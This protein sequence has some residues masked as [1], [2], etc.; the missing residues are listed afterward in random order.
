MKV[1]IGIKIKIKSKGI[2]LT[3]ISCPFLEHR[4]LIVKPSLIL[5]QQEQL[6]KWMSFGDFYTC[7]LKALKIC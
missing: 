4:R 2:L 5:N 7:K 6:S 3:L 1:F